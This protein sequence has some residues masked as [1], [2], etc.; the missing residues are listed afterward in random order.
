MTCTR[1]F[2]SYLPLHFTVKNCSGAAFCS[3]SFIITTDLISKVPP[4]FPANANIYLNYLIAFLNQTADVWSKYFPESQIHNTADVFTWQSNLKI[5]GGI[6]NTVQRN[7]NHDNSKSP[8]KKG[9]NTSWY[10]NNTS[11]NFILCCP[12][13]SSVFH[14]KLT[15]NLDFKSK[16]ETSSFCCT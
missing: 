10:V 15:F 5:C 14:S 9:C 13:T 11:P 1:N 7:Y 12:N 16:C 3:L 6:S 2:I 8:T 4:Y